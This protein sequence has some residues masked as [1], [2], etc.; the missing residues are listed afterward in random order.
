MRAEL[1][2]NLQLLQQTRRSSHAWR[3]PLGLPENKDAGLMSGRDIL[4]NADVTLDDLAATFP[5][6]SHLRD[7]SRQLRERLEIEVKY[8]HEI[9][10]QQEA[11]QQVKREEQMLLP[12]DMDY[13]SLNMSNDAKSKLAEARPASIAAAS[14]IPGMTPAA[15]VILLNHVKSTQ[16]ATSPRPNRR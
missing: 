11:I 13:F 4:C 10:A 15:I 3:R 7:A 9:Q 14:R 1:D 8:S 2:T 6:F 5:E 12:E 16:R